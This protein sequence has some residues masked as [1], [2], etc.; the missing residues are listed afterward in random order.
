[1]NVS[2]KFGTH[3]RQ[4]DY[5]NPRVLL[6][7]DEQS[8]ELWL[9]DESVSRRHAEVYLDQGGNVFIRDLGS[10]NGTWVDG[11]ALGPQPVQLAP[12]QVVYVGHAPLG[13]EWAQAGGGRAAT[14][15]AALPPEMLAM[16]AQRRQQQM[17]APAAPMGF[18]PVAAQAP[19]PMGYAQ[20]PPQ[21]QQAQYQQSIAG[22]PAAHQATQSM[23]HAGVGVAATVGVG[24][25]VGPTPAELTY[26][27]QGNNNNGTL[28]IALAS[29][30]FA[31][32]ST[33]DGFLEFTATDR[34]TVASIFVE[35]VEYHKKGHKKGHVWDR[36]LVRQGPWKTQKG[37]ILPMPFQLRVPSGTSISGP[38]CHWALRGYVD[39]AWALDIEAT[40]PITMRNRDIEKIRDALGALDYRVNT[41]DS[42]PLGQK[43]TGKFNPPMHLRKQLN[44]TDINFDIEY[45]GTNLKVVMEVEKNKLFHRD[46]RQEFVFALDI[47][48]AASLQDTSQHFQQEINKLMS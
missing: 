23:T 24:G 21:Q 25:T 18:A 39:I 34:E 32:E 43:Y 45:L 31:N 3:T 1:M 44:I 2:L 11:Q 30:T 15:M 6:G 38:D 33:L 36:C 20:Q 26:R 13:V 5:T 16:M 19:V 35:L 41:L 46:K 10:S 7:R 22:S 28:L 8:C 17:N 48:R 14:V 42:A 29:D 37:D 12:G 47:L 4:V 40:A 27:R 9:H